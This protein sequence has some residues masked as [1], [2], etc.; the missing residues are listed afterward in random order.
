[1]GAI[2]G[3]RKKIST[4]SVG[5]SIHTLVTILTMCG[6]LTILGSV[7]TGLFRTNFGRVL[8]IDVATMIYAFAA[9]TV[10]YSHTRTIFVIGILTCDA[11]YLFVAPFIINGLARRRIDSHPR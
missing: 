1:M 7:L 8:P 11:A 4:K 5:L 6:V 2:W 10:A 9:A 3:I